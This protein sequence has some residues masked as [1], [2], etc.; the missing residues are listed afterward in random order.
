VHFDRVGY[1][2]VNQYGYTTINTSA[3][4]LHDGLH[5]WTDGFLEEILFA[6]F[7]DMNTLLCIYELFSF[8][9]YINYSRIFYGRKTNRNSRGSKTRALSGIPLVVIAEV[10]SRRIVPK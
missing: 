9:L 5:A 4:R 2:S 7:N 8:G 10:K 1:Q 3:I 6:S